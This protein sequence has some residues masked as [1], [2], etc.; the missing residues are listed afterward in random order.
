MQWGFIAAKWYGP[1]DIRPIVCLHGWQDNA[2]TFDTLIPKLPQQFSYLS[3]DLPGHGFSSHLPP[4]MMY[5]MLNFIHTINHI[6]K[7]YKWDKLSFCSHSMGAIISQLYASLYPDRCDLLICL[8]GLL[9]PSSHSVEVAIEHVRRIGDDFL[10]LDQLSR[11]GKEPPSYTHGEIVERWTKENG[12][13][14][15]ALEHLIKRG[16]NQSKIDPNHFHFSRD[17]RLKIMAM[18]S[19]TM[20]EETHY[21]LMQRIKAPFLFI[22]ANKSGEFVG[23][24]RYQ[25]SLDI[26]TTNNP[27]FQYLTVPGDHHC[28][29]SHPTLV[30][31][32]ITNFINKYRF[33]YRM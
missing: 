17:I 3:I 33:P 12:L 10:S 4:G 2:G 9:K 8:D 11:S 28:H 18:G 13:P 30:S 19:N 16:V 32:H 22:N 29:L 24:E 27:K 7:H 5:S 25:K 23:I 15:E 31:G 21:K 20:T 26:L 6:Q 14:S 1:E